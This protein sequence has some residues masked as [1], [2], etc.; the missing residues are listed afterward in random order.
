M[1]GKDNVDER[2]SKNV[3]AGLDQ[4]DDNNKQERG[5]QDAEGSQKLSF[6][7]ARTRARTRAPDVTQ[8]FCKELKVCNLRARP[9]RYTDSGRNG[10]LPT[11]SVPIATD[12][13]EIY[14]FVVFH[15]SDK[16]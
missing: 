3:D 16:V 12:T 13:Q 10:K 11:S 15:V 9:T 5:A 14:D 7:Y 1:T 8:K 6:E 4:Q 2:V